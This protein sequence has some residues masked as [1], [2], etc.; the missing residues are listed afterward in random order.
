MLIN[1]DHLK[2]LSL[3]NQSFIREILEVYLANNPT[4]L[5]KMKEAVEQKDWKVVRYYA[6][7]LKS[8]S[9][10]IG[11]QRGYEVFQ[12]IEYQIKNDLPLDPIEEWFAEATMVCD[13][14]AKEVKIELTK[15]H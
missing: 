4:D 14:C 8:S 15:Y 12:K 5:D 11:F 7:K 10:T 9:F 3:H 1:L 6:H 2:A 13:Q